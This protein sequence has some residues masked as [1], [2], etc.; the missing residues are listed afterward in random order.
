MVYVGRFPTSLT[1]PV[2]MPLGRRL[3]MYCTS[4]GRVYLSCLDQEARER[5]LHAS[6]L[7]RYTKKTI[8][9][10]PRLLELCDEASEA[11]YAYAEG[12]FYPGDLNVSA[13]VLDSARRPTGVVTISAPSTRWTMAKVRKQLAPLVMETARMIS[14]GEPDPAQ[15]EQFSL[16]SGKK[17]TPRVRNWTPLAPR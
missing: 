13:P 12:E 15:L 17:S 4:A 9:E 8:T 2:H 7:V 1:T 6:D 11:G 14:V 16:G 10:I 5:V 3:P